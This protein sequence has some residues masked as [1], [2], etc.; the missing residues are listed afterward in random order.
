VEEEDGVNLRSY[1]KRYEPKDCWEVAAAGDNV[2]HKTAI[3]IQI[4]TGRTSNEH[5]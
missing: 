3:L 1:K 4:S 2:V 5:G